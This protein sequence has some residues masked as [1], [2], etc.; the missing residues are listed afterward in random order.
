[1]AEYF[2]DVYKRIYLS[3]VILQKRKYGF[4]TLFLKIFHE[5]FRIGLS[6]INLQ[7][8][9]QYPKCDSTNAFKRIFCFSK[10]TQFEVL[11]KADSFLPNFLQKINT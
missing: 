5:Y 3:L 2:C 1:M 11:D 7:I 10:L 4:C 9:E 6:T 8:N